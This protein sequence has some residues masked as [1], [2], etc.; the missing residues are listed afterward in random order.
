L[1]AHESYLDRICLSVSAVGLKG[2]SRLD[3]ETA[4]I[5]LLAAGSRIEFK[6]IIGAGGVEVS[7]YIRDAD[8][9]HYCLPFEVMA[10]DMINSILKEFIDHVFR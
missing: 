4:A 10:S 6:A 2:V 8:G 3:R 1:D 5:R 9:L 7:E